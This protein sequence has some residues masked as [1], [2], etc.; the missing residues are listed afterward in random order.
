MPQ[1]PHPG[2]GTWN[3]SFHYVP[4]TPPM[5]FQAVVS[6]EWLTLEPSR[7]R[8]KWNGQDRWE[9]QDE[10]GMLQVIAF[11]DADPP[12]LPEPRF[13]YTDMTKTPFVAGTGTWQ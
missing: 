2:D 6:G 9:R 10:N 1:Y 13:V 3:C 11:Y 12:L 8:L 5:S 7:E 4:P